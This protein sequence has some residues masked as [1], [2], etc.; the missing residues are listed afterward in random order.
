MNRVIVIAA[1]LS[2]TLLCAFTTTM[3]ILAE[4]DA[5]SAAVAQAVTSPD[6]SEPTIQDWQR[7]FRDLA[8]VAYSDEGFIARA[9][10]ADEVIAYSPANSSSYH[11]S[12]A[13]LYVTQDRHQE[14]L[15]LGWRQQISALDCMT[16]RSSSLRR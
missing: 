1:L 13:W 3:W 7:S 12:C 9:K 6:E 10:A 16:D 4:K 5:G 14:V 15:D 8:K 2:M 11:L